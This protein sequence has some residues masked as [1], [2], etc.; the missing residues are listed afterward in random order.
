MQTRG[1]SCCGH[2][3]QPTPLL[4]PNTCESDSSTPWHTFKFTH[5]HTGLQA[6]VHTCN[7]HIRGRC[8]HKYKYVRTHSA[9][10]PWSLKH[11]HTHKER[12]ISFHCISLQASASPG[13]TNPICCNNCHT[14]RSECFSPWFVKSFIHISVQCAVMKS[15]LI[16]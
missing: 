1:V 8:M 11:T 3:R 7:N 9:Q 12:H 13:S 2:T 10:Q 5:T 4:L 6:H 14:G 16:H 15:I